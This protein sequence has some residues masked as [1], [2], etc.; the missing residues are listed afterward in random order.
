MEKDDQKCEN[1]ND[2]GWIV[3]QIYGKKGVKD[4][5]VDV[6]RCGECGLFKSDEEARTAYSKHMINGMTDNKAKIVEIL[7]SYEE[8]ISDGYGH[9]CGDVD[10][11]LERI[12]KEIL[13]A[14][15]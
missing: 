12:A 6:E 1:C 13:E 2:N 11:T 8:A 5:T 9:Y 4:G 14:I 7:K 10:W 15:Q 3:T